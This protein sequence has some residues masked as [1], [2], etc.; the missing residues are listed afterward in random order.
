MLDLEDV[1]QKVTAMDH[2]KY[3]QLIQVAMKEFCKGYKH[4][5][6]DVMTK[7]AGISKGLLFHYFG[8]KKTVLHFIFNHAIETIITQFF[9]QIDENERDFFK[10]L[11]QMIQVK[12]HFS[13]EHPTL[14]DFF[15]TVQLSEEAEFEPLKEKSAQMRQAFWKLENE[16][17]FSC[18]DR[19]LFKDDLDVDKALQIVMWTAT[20]FGDQIMKKYPTVESYQAEYDRILPQLE[21]YLDLLKKSFYKEM[22]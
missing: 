10:R 15:S 20:G 17:F 22:N 3:Q 8:N 14:F 1:L 4:A 6:T 21:S 9:N 16:S 18:I 5:S 19:T 7:E 11:S 13:Y 2:E 12:V